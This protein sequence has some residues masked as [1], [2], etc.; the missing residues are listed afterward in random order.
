MILST[1]RCAVALALAAALLAT[2]P[3]V[4]P[5]A[6]QATA[7]TMF[8]AYGT[9]TTNIDT[10]GFDEGRAVAVQSD[11][12]IV[13]AGAS[14]G[15]FA[16]V[17]HNT[18]GS[19]DTSFGT[20]GTVTTSVTEPGR[21]GGA[22]AVAIQSDGKI[23]VAGEVGFSAYAVV[24]YN[25]DGSLDTSFHYNGITVVRG[26]GE[27]QAVV[28]Q[29]DGKIIVAGST[30]QAFVVVRHAA[31]GHLDTSF[32][33]DGMA[34]TNLDASAV[35]SAAIQSDGKIVVAGTSFNA[36]SNSD[37][38]VVR[39]NSDGSLDTTFDTD[40]IVTTDIGTNTYDAGHSVAVQSDGKIVVAGRSANGAALVRY[41]TN[42]SLDTTFDTDGKVTLVV[43]SR[44]SIATALQSDAKI[45]VAAV[46]YVRLSVARYD[47]N[48]SLDTMFGTNGTATASAFTSAGDSFNSRTALALQSDGKIVVAGESSRDFAVVRFSTSGSLD[49]G[50]DTDGM[51]TTNISVDGYDA[52][53]SVAVQSDGKIVVAGRSAGDL[54]VVRYNT[55]GSLDTGFDTDGMITIDTGTF[56]NWR[57]VAP[58]AMALQSDGKIVVAAEGTEDFL[59][60]RLN[61]DGS[62]DNG[63]DTDGIVTTDI[64][65]F[66]SDRARAVAVQSNGKIIVA[67]TSGFSNDVAVV[68]YNA[69]GSLDTAFDTDGIV[70][71]AIV[72]AS[73]NDGANAVAVQSNGRII[74]VGTYNDD[75]AV[76]RYNTNGSLDTG[77]DSDG[78]V[79]TDVRV[80][81]PDRANAVAVQNDGKIIVAGQSDIGFDG[82]VAVVR[83]N[84]NGSLDTTFDTDGKTTT[85]LGSSDRAYGVAVQSDG[86]IVVATDSST[87][88]RYN[89]NGSLDSTFDTDGVAPI[90]FP[91]SDGRRVGG[92]LYGVAL[93][94]DGKM[95]VAGSTAS[96]PFS[97]D[98][99]VARYDPASPPPPP[100]PPPRPPLPPRRFTE[101]V[102][103]SLDTGFG[104]G[105]KT[106]TNVSLDSPDAAYE[107]ALQSDGK[108]VVAGRS[109][110]VYTVARYN[111]DG[112]LDATF[113]TD[114]KATLDLAGTYADDEGVGLAVQ[115]D[116]KIVLAGL[117][118]S[119]SFVARY[120]TDGT[121]DTAFGTGGTAVTS[122]GVGFRGARAVAIQSNGRIVVVAGTYDRDFAVVRYNSNGTLDTSFDTDGIATTEIGGIDRFGDSARAVTLS[123]NGKIVVAGTYNG[124]FAVVRYNSNGSL[125]TTFD[126]DGKTTTNLGSSDG[127]YGVAVQS[128]GKIVVAGNTGGNF[129]VVRY[130]TNGTLDTAF[131]ADGR[132][133]T[134]IL[135][136]GATYSSA[137]ARTVTVQSDGKIV[138]AGRASNDFAV[139]RYNTDGTLDTTFDTDGKTTTNIG[140]TQFGDGGNAGA[141]QGD[142]KIVVAGSADNDFALVRYNTDGTLDTTFDTDGKTTTNIGENGDDRTSDMA[143]QS[144]GKIVV[145]GSAANDFALVRYNTDGTLDTTF[146]TD[147]KTTT[148][149]GRLDERSAVAI[150]SDGKIVAAGSVSGEDGVNF[151]VV[152]YN[153]DGTLDTTFD[154]DGR[155]FT[156]VGRALAANAVALQ[157]DGKIIVA[158]S[159]DG[160]FVVLRYNT[161][162]SLDTSFDTDGRTTTNIS[163][164]PGRYYDGAQAVAVQS[165]GKIVAAGSIDGDFVVV[166]YNTDGTRDTS[167]HTD[168][169]VITTVGDGSDDRAGARAVAIQSDGKLVVAGSS[170]GH[171]FAVVRYNTDGSLDTTFDTDGTVITSIR[172]F[173]GSDVAVQADGK[174]IVSGEGT[175]RLGTEIVQAMV[176]VV[177]RYNADGS[178]DTSFATDGLATAY[179]TISQNAPVYG[180]QRPLALQPDG[181]IVVAGNVA[182]DF[183][184]V[185]YD[186]ASSAQV[187]LVTELTVPGAPTGVGAQ[188]Q[189]ASA[190]VSWT[191]PSSDGG[192]SVTGYT[193]T[194][195][196]GGRTCTT[197]GDT[198]C[199]V[200]GLNNGT[201]YT[202][203]VVAHN[204]EGASGASLPSA[205]VT[206]SAGLGVP[207][208]VG[209]EPRDGSV[210][211]SWTAPSFDGG[212]PI[213]GYTA[214]SSPDGRTCNI[215]GAAM[216]TVTGLSNGT[217][218]TFTVTVHNQAGASAVS[219]ASAAVTPRTVPD[220]PTAV[221]AQPDD[222]SAAVSWTAPSFDGGAPITSYT[223]TSSPSGRTCATT[224]G[225]ATACTVT[226]LTN[227]IAY[228]FTV[229]ATNEAGT[230][231]ASLMSAA[232]TPAGAPD[233]PTGVSA[234]P[235]NGSAAVMWTAPSFDGG[236][237]IAGY[238]ATSSPSG[239][240]CATT[241]GAA[242]ACTVTGLTNGTAYTFTVTA[243]N[244][245]STSAASQPS[246]A[247]TPRTV[248][249]APTGVSAQP[250]DA[251][252]AVSWTAPSFNGG[253]PITGYTA[254]SDPDGHTCAT[255]DGA[256]TECTV[257]GLSNGAA[258]TFT[259]TADNEAGTSAVSAPSAAVT[260]RT[261]PDAPTVVLATSSEDGQSVVSW[262]APIFDGG[263]PITGYTAD[264]DRD[265]R[266]C[267][268]SG[269]TATTCTVTGLTNGTAYTFTVTADNEAGTSAVS[270]ASAAATPAGAPGK[271]VSVSA[272]AGD[273]SAVVSWIEPDDTGGPP[274]ISYTATSSPDGQT[275]TAAAATTCTVTVLQRGRAYV[276]TVTATN[277]ADRV[278]AASAPSTEVTVPA[279]APGPPT[280][281]A[282]VAGNGD[283]RV[284]WTVPA[285]TGAPG[286]PV[287]EYEATAAPGDQTCT[288]VGGGTSCTVTGLTN[289]TAHT[290][291]VTA[292]NSLG[293]VSDPSDPSAAVSPQ[294]P[295]GAPDPPTLVTAVVSGNSAVVSWAGPVTAGTVTAS[296]VT[297]SAVTAGAVTAR[298]TNAVTGYEVTAEPGPST[299]AAAA[300]ATSCTVEGLSAG[301]DYTFTVTALNGLDPSAASTASEPAT[302][303]ATAPDAPTGVNATPVDGSATLRWTAPVSHGGSA[304]TSYTATS[305]LHSRT[306]TTA[307]PA[308][309]VA[310]L[311]NGVKYTFTVTARNRRG[312]SPSSPAS[313]AVWITRP[314][315]VMAESGEPAAGEIH[316][317]WTIPD[318]ATSGITISSYEVTS[319]PGQRTC[320]AT[321][322]DTTT[323]TVTGLVNDQP[324]TFTVTATRSD[325]LTATSK[326]SN[327]TTPTPRPAPPRP[328]RPPFRGGGT[329]RTPPPEEEQEEQPEEAV[330]FEDVAE[331]AW[332][333]AHVEH[334]AQLAITAGCTESPPRYCP[335]EPV[336]RAQM[337][338]FLVRALNAAPVEAPTG[339]YNDVPPDAW[340]APHV[341][342]IAQLA[343]TAGCTESPPRY[344]PRDPVTRAQ[345]ALFLYR[346]FD[347]EPASTDEPS[348]GDVGADHYAHGAIEALKAARITAGCQT[349]PALYCPERPVTRAQMAVFIS[350]ALTHTNP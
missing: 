109:H 5:A 243:H 32:G 227:A 53:R 290:F 238:T 139:V 55:N 191:A 164:A 192:L 203:T 74:V 67:G 4:T 180:S 78:I 156:E 241:D 248:P 14:D 234:Q 173:Q 70:T 189:D 47:S 274:I 31:D 226:G 349:E 171:G 6:A 46:G 159:I 99:A 163:D 19:L 50:F 240:T 140:A 267:A 190:V 309:T 106:T 204:S 265:A 185:R 117:R 168:G 152:R 228:T 92:A 167:F 11:G 183:T 52:A 335:D 59:V 195:S 45:I 43:S 54:A 77:F 347:L 292:T 7:A 102:D 41:N 283:A 289:E 286:S 300:P 157:S 134:S 25:T 73:Y 337:A 326:P 58:V 116:G 89:T 145:A 103:E 98:F 153:T 325:N 282:A 221:G 197:V 340:H 86:K 10:N 277:A 260:A 339:R 237:P 285:D 165:D 23:V 291:T 331:D 219:Q 150:Q 215:T 196:P 161:D 184:V 342:R 332:Y 27:A 69:D 111:S 29:S 108:I 144:D 85:N 311:A 222:G 322:P 35:H 223:A 255:T 254:A 246:A 127:A 280:G 350:R 66:S 310:G 208:G 194:A 199:T 123:S 177:A 293:L 9:T 20:G 268:T 48:G 110:R 147:G 328:T 252:A 301:T 312:T 105:G 295:A 101:P 118:N 239:R 79:T 209:G 344:C 299:C 284:S 94:S 318:T 266:T 305:S 303:P 263:A 232:T 298:Q 214:T 176:S 26:A 338:V 182:G 138:V 13:V 120:N 275:C 38:A 115:S 304:I 242:T 175:I 308:C 212:S 207:T 121:L 306:C 321:P 82:D 186:P 170:D 148:S 200:T 345:M 136:A 76:V 39:Y 179:V 269:G 218:Y 75:L 257:T 188:A 258:Y 224:D 211:V 133:T 60:V 128:D 281:V 132:A 63:F 169:T 178:L 24:R 40:G 112:S 95:V 64:G 278:S 198:M 205:P 216:C 34:I 256:A 174:I 33:T 149:L 172:Y 83:Y 158:G 220:A 8:D 317:S 250:D 225:A 302:A 348:F 343:I 93:Q 131:D 279:T 37:F 90:A 80:A 233:A 142:G 135:S 28:L 84:S 72:G 107:T 287:V 122:I 327:S 206:P 217:A 297:V 213:T 71:T 271:P 137:S 249:D 65:S 56:T 100:P 30:H 319:S 126:T 202:F 330:K 44:A 154:T 181:K 346:A 276:F 341:E 229:T 230:S 61:T 104:T 245:A 193:V 307:G 2:A 42:G 81:S 315:G 87:L 1:A 262:T 264:S 162:G 235:E 15:A 231:A 22:S 201:A 236:A 18:D 166:R 88:L 62:L 313:Q 114:G 130:N 288:A 146:D 160:D 333:R 12:K 21:G 336:T 155:V 314:T 296:A 3:A 334:I 16:V 97:S 329:A 210:V 57:N 49:T 273:R 141:V 247:T 113:G 91:G 259:V 129:A 244:E 261:V 294:A 51:A 125:D 323:C 270:Q 272:S 143:L 119:D 96:G 36:T 17:R 151:V 316:V 124:D 68:R 324:Y 320:T 253:A 251:S 187:P